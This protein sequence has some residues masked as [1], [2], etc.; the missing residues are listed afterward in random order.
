V[1]AKQDMDALVN[2]KKE[3]VEVLMTQLGAH[4]TKVYLCKDE[5][6]VEIPEEEYGFFFQ[7]EVYLIDV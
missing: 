3:Q 1:T 2:K 6:N 4:T 7:N 5:K